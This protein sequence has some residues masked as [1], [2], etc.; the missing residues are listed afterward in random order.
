MGSTLGYCAKTAKVR[1][2]ILLHKA[3]QVQSAKG[4]YSERVQGQPT[5]V[6]KIPSQPSGHLVPPSL[7]LRRHWLSKRV[8]LFAVTHNSP[9]PLAPNSLCFA[10]YSVDLTLYVCGLSYT[11]VAIFKIIA[12]KL[13]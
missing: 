13:L 8:Y 5:A 9:I 6:T 3:L 4:T 12:C 7:G 11:S 2:N 1:Y 10:L